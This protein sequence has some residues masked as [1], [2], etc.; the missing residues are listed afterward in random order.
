[1]GSENE[2]LQI[3]VEVPAGAG[4]EDAVLA[5]LMQGDVRSSHEQPASIGMPVMRVEAN[6]AHRVH[7]LGEQAACS[8]YVNSRSV[9]L[10][11]PGLPPGRFVLL[12]TTFTPGKEADFLLRLYTP[13]GWPR[14]REL[15]EDLC[16]WDLRPRGLY[17]RLLELVKGCFPQDY[18]LPVPYTL[19]IIQGH[20][21]P[22]FAHPPPASSLGE[23]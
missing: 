7:R 8:D 16:G 6:R 14:P 22:G 4:P 1:M 19:R 12:P 13:K 23:E 11:L 18:P 21:I 17:G 9:S 10:R 20:N 5:T 3:V 15:T 2:S